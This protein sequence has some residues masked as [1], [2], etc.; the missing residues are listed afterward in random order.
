[1]KRKKAAVIAA[2]VIAAAII[3]DILISRYCL[4]TRHFEVNCPSLPEAFDG[5]R[6]AQISDLHNARFG[7]DNS[8]LIDAV[9]R[10]NP[11]IIALTGD[12]VDLH[13]ADFN[14]AADLL[15]QLSEIAPCYYVTGN[16]EIRIFRDYLEFEKTISPFV[17]SLHSESIKVEKDGEAIYICGIDDPNRSAAFDRNL[18]KLGKTDGF[19]VLLSHRPERFAQYAGSGFD[20]VLSGHTHGG[21]VRLPFIGSVIAPS[22]G[23]FPEYDSGLY[24]E[25][26][27][28]MIISRGLGASDIPVRFNNR[29]EIVIIDLVCGG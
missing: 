4:Y 8:K 29:P 19:K 3:A 10:E 14:K 7:K 28:T 24:S 15:K 21:Q 17:N 23:F 5:F 12:I 26:N 6:I 9:K 13:T 27:T 16:H 1:M 2:S 20:L 11:D 18:E 25:G 22:Q